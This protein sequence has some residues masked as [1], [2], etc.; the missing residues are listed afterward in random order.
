V[1]VAPPVTVAPLAASAPPASS[2]GAEQELE[3]LSRLAVTG[4]LEV[5]IALVEHLTGQRIQVFDPSSVTAGARA[6]PGQAPAPP[7]A[8]ARPAGASGGTGGWRVDAESV[9]FSTEREATSFLASGTVVGVDGREINVS[10]RLDLRRESVTVTHLRTP[11]AG[12]QP[13]VDPLVVAFGGGQVALSGTDVELDLTGDGRAERVAFVGAGSGFL[14]IDRNGNGVVDDGGELF[15]PAT[16]DGYA[17][18]AAY[19]DDG[20]GWI[21]SGD[22]AYAD[23]RLWDQVGGRLRTLAERGVAAIGLGNVATPWDLDVEGERAGVLR[24][25]GLWLGEDGSAGVTAHVDLAI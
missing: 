4:R 12:G 14:A 20:N 16:G 6:E 25:T 19:D 2:T 17:E 1:T 22:G 13:A 18:L 23:L 21:D 3:G 11:T 24:S 7:Q 10:V 5:M 8:A 9:V 15:G